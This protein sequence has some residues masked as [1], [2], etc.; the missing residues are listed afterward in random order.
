MSEV[1]ADRTVGPGGPG[2]STTL[3]RATIGM[4]LL[5]LLS[6]VAQMAFRRAIREMD[7]GLS[8]GQLF[9]TLTIV[10]GVIGSAMGLHAVVRQK[11]R[12]ALVFVVLVPMLLFTLF[13]VLFAAGEIF[14]P[15]E[16]TGG[17]AP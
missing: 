9:V 4:G 2:P 13:W 3:G 16:G 14:F 7:L 17:Y 15:T 8:P 12:S 5:L 6:I 10:L 11:E 1:N